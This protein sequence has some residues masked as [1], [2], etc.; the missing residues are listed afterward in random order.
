[1]NAE[2][3]FSYLALAFA[4]CETRP[5]VGRESSRLSEEKRMHKTF[6]SLFVLVFVALRRR[7]DNVT[8]QNSRKVAVD[9]TRAG[10]VLSLAMVKIYQ[11]K[12]RLQS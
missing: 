3:S 6:R 8:V 2:A 9:R 11:G 1:M 10:W 4:L 12:W 7:D 5:E